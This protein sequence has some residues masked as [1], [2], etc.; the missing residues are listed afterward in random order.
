MSDQTPGQTDVFYDQVG[1]HETFV[2]LVDAFYEG[3]AE[4]EILRPMYPEADL[5]PAKERMT[6]FLEIGRA[7]CRERV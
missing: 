6:L 7:S 5:G 3:V 4:D 2:R 1:G